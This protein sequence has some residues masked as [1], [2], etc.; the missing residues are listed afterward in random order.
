LKSDISKYQ[1]QFDKDQF[2]KH[3]GIQLLEAFP[4]YAKACM[5]IREFHL[6]SVGVL[7]GGALFTLAD[8]TFAVASNA[9]GR[10]ALAI[11]AEISFFKAIQSGVLTATAREISLNNKLGTYLIDIFNEKEE[12][13]ANFKGTVYRKN[14]TLDFD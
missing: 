1:R 2:A 6:N 11:D 4:G 14:E 3:N 13:I 8:F 5:E 12:L 7:H 10:V 9:H